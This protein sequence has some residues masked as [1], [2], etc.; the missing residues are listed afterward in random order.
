M[1]PFTAQQKK[2][3]VIKKK[4]PLIQTTMSIMVRCLGSGTEQHRC[5]NAFT[6]NSKEHSPR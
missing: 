5:F 6:I 2:G 4:A 1:L 3:H